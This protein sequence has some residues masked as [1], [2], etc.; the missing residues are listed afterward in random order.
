[1]VTSPDHLPGVSV[2]IFIDDHPL[3]ER[4]MPDPDPQVRTVNCLVEA[5]T[6]K[7]FEIRMT[8]EENAVFEGNQLSFRA[9]VDGNCTGSCLISQRRSPTTVTS[10]GLFV[11]TDQVRKYKFAN[12]QNIERFSQSISS[13]SR[14][15]RRASKSPSSSGPSV[16][17][18]SE[19]LYTG[20][21]TVHKSQF[22]EEEVSELGTIK[23]E[24]FHKNEVS[25][26]EFN[27]DLARE[28]EI[29]TIGASREARGRN[30]MH[31]VRYVSRDS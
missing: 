30:T 29:A 9:H 27:T 25:K 18:F 16:A 20:S 21:P 10:E 28:R 26:S 15:V 2:G 6:D 19:V 5:E 31:C 7:I 1:M 3:P 22:T 12:I 8:T 23:V 11:A 24:V 13:R 17:N 14:A 4:E